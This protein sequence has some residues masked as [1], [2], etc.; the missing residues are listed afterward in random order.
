MG[1][2]LLLAIRLHGDDGQGGARYHGTWQGAPEWP[3][4]PARVFQALVA[5]GARGNMLPE[6]LV[7]ALEW[8]E[9]LSPPVIA[10]PRAH[11]GERV[12]VFVPNN[13]A[14]A[15]AD[16]LDVSSIRTKKTVHP[17]LLEGA[18]PFLYV[19]AL[20]EAPL[21]VT[22]IIEAAN[23]IYQLGRGVDMAWAA[24]EVLDD[25]GLERRLRAHAGT[26]HRPEV[27]VSGRTLPCPAPGSLDSLLQRHRATKLQVEGQGRLT[28]VLFLNAPK[29]RFLSV[30]YQ[31]TRYR[32]I[33][34][35]R[36]RQDDTKVWP[37][38]LHRATSLVE[39]L[40]DGAAERL[41]QGLPA[42]HAA[43]ER[44]LIGR[45]ADGSDPAPT[46]QRVRIIPLPSIG[47]EHV[48]RAIRRIVLD[49]PS[50]APLRAVDV[51]WAFSGL[52]A[53][54]PETGVVGPFVLGRSDADNM[55]RHY[56]GPARRWRTVTAVALPEN[57]RRRR[58]DPA[59]RK[60]EPKN[61]SERAAEED[62]AVAAVHVAL[63]HADVRATAIEVH[64][65]REPF[66]GRGARA[67]AF[68]EGT[69]FPKERLWHVE[70]ELDRAVEGPLVIGDGRF[71]GLGVMAPVTEPRETVRHSGFIGFEAGREAND[72]A[73]A[74]ATALRRAV[75]ARV[76]ARLGAAPLG[77]FFSGH[78]EDGTRVVSDHASHL[79]FQWDPIGRRLLVIAP[80]WLDRREPLFGERRALAILDEALEDFTELR[81]GSAGRFA[82]RRQPIGSEDRLLVASMS[83]RSVTPY[84]VTRHK[85]HTTATEV[86]AED[87]A[88]E[89]RRQGLP[90]PKVTV[91][92]AHGVPGR[93]LEG[94]V[95]LDFAVA[96]RGPVILGR[97][98]YLGG[99]LFAPSSG[100]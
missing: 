14:D 100:R 88:A 29:P 63:R 53:I 17:T 67:E 48:D 26:V 54:N 40:R 13:D 31:R 52:E 65:Q 79:A 57:A 51:E 70:L 3:P 99:G 30:V 95:R 22:T 41:R 34:E 87:A 20:P 7:S 62:R 35:L 80:H 83:W 12:D 16:P 75:M 27:N 56:S 77:R 47:H 19:W 4:A 92:D 85:K 91:L 24:G 8:L 84:A 78:E 6:D 82:L 69:R 25:D 10:A 90:S 18:V 5:G 28:T 81:A 74:L 49:V 42:E 96:V 32:V 66:E 97:T 15:L 59:R 55:V 43:I 58:I 93:G 73:T 11:Q 68:A 23:D 33:Y 64:V 21:H 39:A 76:Q 61:A 38:A 37:W 50:G 2:H 36:D 86:L 44:T 71:L 60:E 72:D 94:R 46:E 89:C 45:K 9:T 1:Q 98:R